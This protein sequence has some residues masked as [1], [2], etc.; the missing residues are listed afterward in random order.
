MEAVWTRFQPLTLEVK[1]IAESGSLG[2]PIVL[3]ADLSGN[4][5]INSAFKCYIFDKTPPTGYLQIFPKL[6][7]YWTLL[8]EEEL[9]SICKPFI[10]I[11]LK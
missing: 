8:L 11:S 10:Y 2:A 6:I 9:F 4:F 7:E 3:H 1:K 5:D